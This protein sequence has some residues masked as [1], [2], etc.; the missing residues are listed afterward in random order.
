M[1]KLTP[2]PVPLGKPK[3]TEDQYNKVM[4]RMRQGECL[5][6]KCLEHFEMTKEQE[7]MIRQAEEF[8]LILNTR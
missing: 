3:M 2:I 4:Y 8:N 6:N 5:L 7:R 1:N